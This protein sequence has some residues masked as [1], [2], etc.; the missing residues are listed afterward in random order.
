M[1]KGHF[2]GN[3][4]LL[5][6]MSLHKRIDSPQTSYGAIRNDTLI[7]KN[8]YNYFFNSSISSRSTGR[9][10][11]RDVENTNNEPMSM[12]TMDEEKTRAGAEVFSTAKNA[13]ELDNEKENNNSRCRCREWLRLG[14]TL[15]WKC[16]SATW[17]CAVRVNGT[18]ESV[19]RGLRCLVSAFHVAV[20]V[21]LIC[22]SLR[23]LQSL[24]FMLPMRYAHKFCNIWKHGNVNGL[25]AIIECSVVQSYIRKKNGERSV[26]HRHET[27]EREFELW[28]N[29]HSDLTIPW[30]S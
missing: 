7:R 20:S 24:C 16:G 6:I 3:R 30:P 5:L 2:R 18:S 28:T 4:S 22:T 29:R 1:V 21:R 11:E 10:S 26:S 14:P 9:R 19:H 27:H 25:K 12:P 17:L 15:R 8:Y 13:V 23:I